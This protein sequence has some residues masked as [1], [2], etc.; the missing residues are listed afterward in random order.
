MNAA[1]VALW[2][3]IAFAMQA[4]ECK[5]AALA[6]VGEPSAS[7]DG[8][9]LPECGDLHVVIDRK[10]LVYGRSDSIRVVIK[11]L[12]TDSLML[13]IGLEG[14]LARKGWD[15]VIYDMKK[16]AEHGWIKDDRAG[17]IVLHGSD[18]AR[19]VLPLWKLKGLY[20]KYTRWRFFIYGHTL[21]PRP[22]FTCLSDLEPFEIR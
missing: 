11:N 7:Y 19:I 12:R 5:D 6:Y 2:A 22:D 13:S 8:V 10:K 4:V 17:L 21:Y 16:F 18:S 20:K 1:V 15:P 9:D 14:Y 3:L